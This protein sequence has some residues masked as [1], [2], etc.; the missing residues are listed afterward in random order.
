MSQNVNLILIKSVIKARRQGLYRFVGANEATRL[1]CLKDKC[2][3]CCTSIG[4]PVVT[5]QEAD[6]IGTKP[7]VTNKDSMFIRSSNCVCSLLE[8]GLCSIHTARPKGCREYPWYNIQGYLYYDAGCPGIKHD[9]DERP[10]ASDIQPFENFFPSLP[11]FIIWLIKK[12]CVRNL[13]LKC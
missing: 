11:K 6:R 1:D 5:S 9:L 2:A 8:N 4:T 7:I 13:K 12:I 10:N 3:I